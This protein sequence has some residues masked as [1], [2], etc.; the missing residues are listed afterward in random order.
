MNVMELAEM[1]GAEEEEEEE[2]EE[3]GWKNKLR[4][5]SSVYRVQSSHIPLHGYRPRHQSS[6]VVL[7]WPQP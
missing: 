2:E 7:L 4:I 3:P 6:L 1:E 5:E